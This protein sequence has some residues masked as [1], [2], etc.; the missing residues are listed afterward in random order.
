M[1]GARVMKVWGVLAAALGLGG[2]IF[3]ASAAELPVEP[4]IYQPRPAVLIFRWTGVYIGAHVGGGRGFVDENGQP[5]S[6][7]LEPL[8]TSPPPIPVGQ[9]CP[10]SAVPPVCSIVPYP[11][12]VGPSGWLAGGQIG[13]NYQYESWVIGIEGQASWAPFSSSSSC[14][15][16]EQLTFGGPFTPI[17]V[18]CTTKLDSLGTAAVR[19]GWAFDRLL[20]YGKG[21]AAWTNNS[22]QATFSTPNGL[23]LLSTNELRWGWMAG[24]GVEYAFTDVWSAKLEYNYMDLGADSLLLLDVNGQVAMAANFRERINVVKIGVNYRFGVTPIWVR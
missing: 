7:P 23:L 10:A 21:G 4:I 15:A 6:F 11:T 1:P 16:G 19:L 14:A 18:N 17:A 8:S 12:S 2:I 20:V 9:P 3:P 5:L 22:H 13:A 24:I